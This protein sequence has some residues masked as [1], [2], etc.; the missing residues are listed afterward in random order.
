MPVEAKPLFRPD[1]LRGHVDAYTLP[2]HV[3]QF[4]PKLEHWADL[5]R[6]ERINRFNEQ[7]I[8]PDFI[9]DFFVTLLGYRGPAGGETRHTISRECNVV[10]DGKRVDA[11]LGEFNGESKYVVALEGKGPKD[12]LDR[13]YAGR[14]MS[15]VDQG[16]RY[17]IN[18]PCDWI[19]VTSTRETRLYHKGSD[20]HTYER[21]DTY[22]LFD[23]EPTL[24][25]FV[26]LLYC[27][28]VVLSRAPR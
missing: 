8:L 19:I 6:S 3:E 14:R 16:Y 10:V 23:D 22:H 13:A 5:I 2:P 11:V 21:F 27:T 1:V 28:L 20:Q 4:R 24:R 12:P 26:F 18:L 17:A 25:R 9:T 7:Q 15:A